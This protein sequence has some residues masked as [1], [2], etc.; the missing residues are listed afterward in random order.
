M[1][2]IF[3]I[4]LLFGEFSAAN[5]CSLS[6]QF[7][8]L[9]LFVFFFTFFRFFSGR[10][11]RCIF[12]AV[13]GMLLLDRFVCLFNFMSGLVPC[14]R[15][16]GNG[17]RLWKSFWSSDTKN[18]ILKYE[19]FEIKVK[20]RKKSYKGHGQKPALFVFLLFS[21]FFI[22]FALTTKRL[23]QQQQQQRPPC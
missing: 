5:F 7:L 1:L 19:K 21:R 22:I 12:C 9:L 16:E 10:S 8:I 13:A 3:K 23:Q 15:R 11:G 20:P 17:K 2:F 14:K 6:V 4:C 18:T